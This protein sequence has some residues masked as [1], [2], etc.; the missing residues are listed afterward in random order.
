VIR[1]SDEPA[2]LMKVGPMLSFF[3]TTEQGTVRLLTR[4]SGKGVSLADLAYFSFDTWFAFLYKC[5]A[6]PALLGASATMPRLPA[7]GASAS[8]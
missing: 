6:C 2:L 8:H 3:G 5:L 1:A 4:S 7:G